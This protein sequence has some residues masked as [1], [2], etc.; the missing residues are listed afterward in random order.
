MT[1]PKSSKSDFWSHLAAGL[2][3]RKQANLWRS[4]VPAEG[5]SATMIERNGKSLVHF[6]SNDYLS[7]AWHPEVRDQFLTAATN[8]K[9]GSGASPLICGAGPE[10]Q[11]LVHQIA[12][13]KGTD[14][15]LIFSSG[16]AANVGAIRSV[17]SREDLILSDALNHAC[18]I[19]GCQLSRAKVVVY[20]HADTDALE[21]LLALHRPQH[22]FAFVVTDTVF[23]MDGDLAPI[24]RIH[25]LCEQYDAI[26]I[27][28]EAHASGVI[29]PRGRGVLAEHA[30]D[31]NASRNQPPFHKERWIQTGTL[32]KA[33]GCSGGFVSGSELLTSWMIHHARSWIYSTAMPAAILVAA[34]K[35]I[36]LLQSMES[37]RKQLASTSDQLRSRLQELGFKTRLDSTPIIPIYVPSPSDALEMS[38]HLANSGYFVPA[39]RPPTVPSDGSLLRVSLNISHTPDQLDGLIRSLE[40][41]RNKT[42]P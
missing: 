29:G 7:L 4:L 23:S 25:Q 11:N 28:D 18:L 17:A 16:Y 27:A 41:A 37:Q 42:L 24:A 19:D 13:W 10:Y 22:R 38:Q 21:Q 31:G 1:E 26:G 20:P 12:S 6:G 2:Q 9:V 14:S 33:I 35:A 36:E 32:S 34:T 40:S 3:Y 15:A 5:I 30:I 8:P 39:I